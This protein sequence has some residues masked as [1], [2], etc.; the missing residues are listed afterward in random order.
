MATAKAMT[1]AGPAYGGVVNAR[2]ETLALSNP[3]VEFQSL[4][5][6]PLEFIEHLDQLPF[7]PSG[8]PILVD[9]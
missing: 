3:R 4:R 7:D 6:D 9:E 8:D 1:R 5:Y 2:P